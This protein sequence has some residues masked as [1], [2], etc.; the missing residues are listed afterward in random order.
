MPSFYIFGICYIAVRLYSNLFG[1]LILFYLVYVVKLGGQNTEGAR[2]NFFQALVPLIVCFMSICS[3][4]MLSRFYSRFGRKTALLIGGLICAG[5]SAGLYFLD[6]D[7]TWPIYPLSVLVGIKKF[8]RRNRPTNGAVHR[9]KSNIGGDWHERRV[10]R[11]SLW[12]VQLLWQG[13]SGRCHLSR[14]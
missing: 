5:T 2:I 10:G 6:S 1:T 7:T 3:N 13:C 11:I 12:S 4:M 8:K 14:Y 9:L